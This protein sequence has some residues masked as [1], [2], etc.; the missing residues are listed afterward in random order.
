MARLVFSVLELIGDTPLV[1]LQPLVKPGWVTVLGK[2]ESLRPGGSSKAG[3]RA[4]RSRKPN[5]RGRLKPG[6][7]IVEPTSGKAGI[8]LAGE[9]YLSNP[10]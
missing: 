1:R 7:T 6:D 3:S 9:Q 5:G 4:P 8:G 10:T 2:L